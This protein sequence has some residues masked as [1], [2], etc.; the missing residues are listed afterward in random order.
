M[1]PVDDGG[2]MK[3]WIKRRWRSVHKLCDIEGGLPPGGGGGALAP[4]AIISEQISLG[5]QRSHVSALRVLA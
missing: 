2:V 4:K 3:E 5:N 1:T